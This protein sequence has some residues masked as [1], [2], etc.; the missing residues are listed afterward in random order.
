MNAPHSESD[1]SIESTPSSTS[2]ISPTP[3]ELH[4]SA[5]ADPDL[6]DYVIIDGGIGSGLSDRESV[7]F[8]L[9]I[10]TGGDITHYAY[11]PK[12]LEAS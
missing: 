6:Y 5:N 4:V 2:K 10:E 9:V 7:L 3:R 11:I 12:T 1:H 8:I